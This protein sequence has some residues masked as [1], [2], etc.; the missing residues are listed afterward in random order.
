MCESQGIIKS[1]D[2]VNPRTSDKSQFVY[3]L[4]TLLMFSQKTASEQSKYGTTSEQSKICQS[5]TLAS[6]MEKQTTKIYVQNFPPRKHKVNFD[7]PQII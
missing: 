2:N 5:D 7:I 1:N 4:A 3:D 6:E